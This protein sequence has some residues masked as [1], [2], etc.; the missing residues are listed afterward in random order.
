MLKNAVTFLGEMLRRPEHTGSIVPSSR[1]LAR[2]MA[3]N[4]TPGAGPVIEL[5]PGTGSITREIL[6]RGIAP[7]DLH[8]IEMNSTFCAMLRKQFP[9]AHV[10][11]MSAADIGALDLPPAQAVVSSLPLLNMPATL[12]DAILRASLGQMAPGASFVQF[13]YGQKAPISAALC[14]ALDLSW[15]VSQRIW[16]NVPPAFVYRFTRG[17]DA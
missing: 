16:N 4:L 3:A 11:Q 6:A 7:D 9:G 5:G 10:H 2:E 15:T 14:H 12:H 1:R 17:Q 8:L 13:T